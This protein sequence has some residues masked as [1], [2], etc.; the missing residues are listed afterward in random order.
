[1]AEAAGGTGRAP[2]RF[3]V[4]AGL[5]AEVCARLGC[6]VPGDLTQVD[7][8]YRRWL[9]QVWFDP[10][11]KAL[12]LRE[13]RTPDG[14]DAA[15][16]GRRWLET[17]LGGTCWAQSV[18][19][20]SL[21]AAS[22]ADPWITL[23]RMVDVAVVD[24]HCAVVVGDGPRRLVYDLIHATDG[25]LPL[26]DGAASTRGRYTVSLDVQDGRMFHRSL[27][28]ERRSDYHLLSTHLDRGDVEAFLAVSASHSGLRRGRFFAR[29]IPGDGHVKLRAASDGTALE[30]ETFL[31][32][33]S[34]STVER[35]SD[36]RAGLV[37]A[38][39][40]PPRS[41]CWN[42]RA[43]SRRRTGPWCSP[44]R[45]LGGEGSNLY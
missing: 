29:R 16:W 41:A 7:A 28:G 14:A 21:L 2:A 38:A 34:P 10:V 11:G 22:G 31:D 19:F 20:A 37:A 13:G 42:A 9:D 27:L 39:G 1:M 25:G 30:V 18:G 3:A 12:A 24:F 23:E 5:A 17:G 6:P 43:S 35:Y 36:I 33:A 4:D 40:T 8:L 44:A 45:Q 15:A 26:V 32:A